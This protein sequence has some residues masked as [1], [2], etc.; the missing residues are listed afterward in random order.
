MGQEDQARRRW[1][2]SHHVRCR[3]SFTTACIAWQ[4]VSMTNQPNEQQ[5]SHLHREDYKV[6]KLVERVEAKLAFQAKTT[7]EAQAS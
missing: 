1:C 5:R 2:V 4:T 3:T 6:Q 7:R